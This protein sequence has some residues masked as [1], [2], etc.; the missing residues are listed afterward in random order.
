MN[1]SGKV[2][3]VTGAASGI[4]EACARTFAEN[5]AKLVLADRDAVRGQAVAAEIVGRRGAAVFVATD[6]TD[7][8]AISAMV[9]L[10]VREFGGLD[11]AVNAAGI[12]GA[13]A[14]VT[15]LTAA[16]WRLDFEVMLL[17]VA[18]C[19]KYE[20]PAMQ[21]R[22]GGSIVNIASTGGLGGVPMMASYSAAKHGVIGATKAAAVENA[23]AGIR[24]N[25]L[26]P[27]LIDTPLFRGKA[28]EGADYSAVVKTVPMGRLGQP[29][30]IADA[31][32]W[33]LS[34]R[35]SFVTGQTIVVDGGLI[36]STFGRPE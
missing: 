28:D 3:V 35:S 7:E 9:D 30:E 26:C 36:T 25:A 12:A 6:V 8:E 18:L 17:G 11:G 16:R 15:D 2:I 23:T 32:F 33:L 22:G 10:A 14:F 34:S 24:V 20:I 27:G 5:G 21:R 19:M 4:G 29:S 31:A 1:L 13:P